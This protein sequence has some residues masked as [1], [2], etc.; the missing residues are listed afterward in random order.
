[1]ATEPAAT[2]R[3]YREADGDLSIL[4]SRK[5]AVIGYGNQGKSQALNLRDSGIVPVIGTRRDETFQAAKRD[6]FRVLDTAEAARESDVLLLLIPDEIL[7]EVFKSGI[8]PGLRPDSALCFASGYCVAFKTVTPPATVDVVLVAPRMI[9]IGVRE[10]YLSGAGFP[11]FVG[12]ERDATGQA[13][14]IAL[15]IA[16]GI[17]SLRCGALELT[18]AQEAAIDLFTEQAFGPAF[19]NALLAAIEVEQEAGLPIEAILLEL[20]MSGEFS[21]AMA[22][23]AEVGLIRQMD[24]HSQTSQY[25]SS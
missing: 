5:V 13:R 20:Y 22:K 3:V 11:S 14:Q 19:G 16:K 15:A 25:G 4:R 12:V 10:T 18:F 8:L 9:G 23:A 17:G 7:P 1:M 2:A 6:G 24:Y 21:H